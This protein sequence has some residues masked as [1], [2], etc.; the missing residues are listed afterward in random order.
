[1]ALLPATKENDDETPGRHYAYR[2]ISDGSWTATATAATTT[3]VGQVQK[4]IVQILAL[5]THI[6]TDRPLNIFHCDK[7]M[8]ILATD[9]VC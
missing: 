3:I 8:Y 1:M 2:I 9:T 4:L 5:Y 7:S 6:H